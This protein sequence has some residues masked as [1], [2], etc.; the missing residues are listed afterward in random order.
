MATILDTV[1][2][3]LVPEELFRA[4][5]LEAYLHAAGIRKEADET[6]VSSEPKDSMVAVMAA[7]AEQQQEKFSS[8]LLEMEMRNGRAIDVLISGKNA[9]M[10]CYTQKGLQLAEAVRMQYLDDILYYI[11][12]LRKEYALENTDPIYVKGSAALCEMLIKY[13]S[14]TVCV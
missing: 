14:N 10:R 11:M 2:V 12:A 8:P 9:Y 6:A 3:T 13:H 7:S 5:K 4:D 1:K